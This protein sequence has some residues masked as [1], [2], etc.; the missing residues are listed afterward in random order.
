[1]FF[2]C[3]KTIVAPG[4]RDQDLDRGYEKTRVHGSR[5]FPLVTR[6]GTDTDSDDTPNPQSCVRFR[7][8]VLPRPG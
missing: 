6:T 2:P 8:T 7:S 1:M 4:T 3:L 5:H